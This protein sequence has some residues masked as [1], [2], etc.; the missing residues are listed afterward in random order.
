MYTQPYCTA[1][2]AMYAFTKCGKTSA[3]RGIG[4]V[5]PIKLLLKMPRYQAAFASLGKSWEVSEEL[6]D[7]IEQF[8]WQTKI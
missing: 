4:K 6:I 1:L 8:V 5:K 2:L 3:F 7:T